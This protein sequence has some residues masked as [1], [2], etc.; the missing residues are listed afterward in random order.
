VAVYLAVMFNQTAFL[1]HVAGHQ[2]ISGSKRVN[3]LLGRL[4]GNPLVG[5]SYGWS[6]SKHNRHHAH[7]N[8]VDR[9]P[10]ISPGAIA[11]TRG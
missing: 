2:Q 1:G 6:T 4:H 8:Q 5:L 7:P 10:D 11:F 3:D 9:D